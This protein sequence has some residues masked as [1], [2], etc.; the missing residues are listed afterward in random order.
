MMEE[1]KFEKGQTLY[2]VNL[3]NNEYPINNCKF[4]KYIYRCENSDCMCYIQPENTEKEEIQF[5]SVL[6]STIEE[7]QI[8]RSNFINKRIDFEEK[9]IE[10]CQEQ[11]DYYNTEIDFLKEDL[12]SYRKNLHHYKE[13]I[14][15]SKKYIQNLKQLLDENK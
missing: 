6:F 1:K 9:H 7:A 15:N 10:Y 2:L 11:Y 4:V 8:Y 5:T 14:N 3:Y 13:A 12:K